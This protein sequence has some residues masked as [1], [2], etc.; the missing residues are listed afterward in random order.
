MTRL[1]YNGLATGSAGSLSDL[2]LSG[3]HTNSTTTL[4]F[5]A[6]LTHSNGTAV[7][8]ITGSDYFMLSILDSAGHVAEIVKVT[9][10]TSGG[11]TATVTRGEEG[12]SGV[13]HSSGAKVVHAPTN[14]DMAPLDFDKA[15]RTAGNLT[16]TA[17]GWK[18]VGTG[19]IADLVLD[20]AAGDEIEVQIC[21]RVTKSS[22]G[23]TF[24][25]LDAHTIVSGSAVNSVA[26]EVAATSTSVSHVGWATGNLSTT[27]QY[28]V[29]K[30]RYTLLTGD[31]ASGAVT[32]RLRYRVGSDVLL[33]AN[34]DPH[35][36]FEATNLGPRPSAV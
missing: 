32:L 24:C 20:A 33:T 35:V 8:T 25:V 18:D 13:S 29:S 15:R 19:N 31:I 4:T 28:L 14:Q 21:A 9:A 12:T 1:R 10:Y 3:S 22:A 5:N 11:T 26:G 23:T 34:G 27:D 16:L 17:S 36:Y 7:S 2:T 30:K 6:A